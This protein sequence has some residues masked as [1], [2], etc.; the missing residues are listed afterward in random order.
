MALFDACLMPVCSL[1]HGKNPLKKSQSFCYPDRAWDKNGRR[2]GS[3]F[4]GRTARHKSRNAAK[5]QAPALGVKVENLTKKLRRNDMSISADTLYVEEA[6]R[7]PDAP[8][9]K[10]IKMRPGG[11]AAMAYPISYGKPPEGCRWETDA[12]FAAR[13]RNAR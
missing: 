6:L 10:S 5:T 1:G 7:G 4:A 8:T 9:R 11:V 3:D 13:L 12:E 2:F